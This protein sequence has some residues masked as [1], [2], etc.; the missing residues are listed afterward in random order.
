VTLTGH[1]LAESTP[2][3]CDAHPGGIEAT[4]SLM[5]PPKASNP[6]SKPEPH[7]VDVDDAALLERARGAA[8]GEK[9]SRLWA[10]DTSG[11]GDDDSAADDAL[12]CLLAYWTGGD[13][14]RMDRLFRQ[15]ALM[16]DKWDREDYRARTIQSA[17]ELVTEHYSP[18]GYSSNGFHP[19][20]GP[21]DTEEK[22]WPER[23]ELTERPSAPTLPEWM[24]PT[25]FRASVLDVATRACI[26]LEM[27]A[28][29]T[30]NAVGALVLQRR[31]QGGTPESP[32]R[33]AARRF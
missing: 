19:N 18:N 2:D 13:A 27:V 24:I 9:F 29:P 33:R 30:I 17:Q 25:P 3:I 22:T 4:Y 31:L 11:Y 16:R 12:C 10:G 15:S 6:G 32:Q 14:A 28:V 20:Q 23:Q 21:S 7:S 8:N 26:P 5:F 1:T